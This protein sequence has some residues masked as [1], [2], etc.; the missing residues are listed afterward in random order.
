MK[1]SQWCC[2]DVGQWL[3][4]NTF[5]AYVDLLCKQHQLDG[6]AL[7]TLTEEDLK[8]P[9]LQLKVLGDIKRIMIC[10]RKLQMVNREVIRDLPILEGSSVPRNRRLFTQRM[11]SEGSTFSEEM[12][13]ADNGKDEG[14]VMRR[15]QMLEPEYIKLIISYIYMF[16]AFL[17]TSFVM[18][19]VHDRVPDM[20]KYPPLPDIML[21]SLPYIPWA[22]EMCEVT[23]IIL[24]CTWMGIL[25][26]HKHR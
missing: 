15:S 21:D 20:E 25:F 7:L 9:P 1:V 19:I 22:F 13:Y 14:R 26:F 16:S 8:Q 2:E 5:S 11:D 10:V 18:V 24:T 12:D 4:E 3:E 23:V 6:L 17:L